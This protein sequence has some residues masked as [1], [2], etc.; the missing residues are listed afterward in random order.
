M[1][2]V[3]IGSLRHRITIEYPVRASDGGG[4]ALVAWMPLGPAWA[5]ITPSTG[6]E[7]IGAEAIAGHI[8][9]EIVMRHRN[10]IAPAMRIRLGPRTFEI[11]AA[12]DVDERRRMLRC[13]AR[14]ER[15]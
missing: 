11:L 15:L 2:R 5:A 4:G 6:A 14:E 9:H 13:F 3:P 12:I 1:K 7:S 8:S 10:D